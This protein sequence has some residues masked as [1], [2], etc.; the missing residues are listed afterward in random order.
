MNIRKLFWKWL[1]FTNLWTYCPNP[2]TKTSTAVLVCQ[3]VPVLSARLYLQNHRRRRGVHGLRSFLICVFSSRALKSVFDMYEGESVCTVSWT[4]FAVWKQH[5][6]NYSPVESL[7]E[8]MQPIQVFSKNTQRSISCNITFKW[9]FSI[10]AHRCQQWVAHMLELLMKWFWCNCHSY[11]KG[12]YLG[13]SDEVI[14][15]FSLWQLVWWF[16]NQKVSDRRFSRLQ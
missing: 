16:G 4:I 6:V 3:Y 7:N 10:G 2:P 12:I 8:S 5:T 9:I 15:T 1:C 11:T 14:N 13:S